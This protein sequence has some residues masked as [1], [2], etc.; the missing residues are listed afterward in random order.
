MKIYTSYYGNLKKLKEKNVLA[1]GI[2]LGKPKW[3]TG[4]MYQVIAPTYPILQMEDEKIYTEL[5][6]KKVLGLV[7]AKK[8]YDDLKMLSSGRDVA[9]LCYEKPEDFCHRHLVAV[10]LEKNLNIT[11]SEFGREKDKRSNVRIEA[12]KEVPPVIQTNLFL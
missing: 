8:V 4:M 11:V 10:W 12:P 2:S 6:V 7:K 5:F 1:I 9:I 3:F